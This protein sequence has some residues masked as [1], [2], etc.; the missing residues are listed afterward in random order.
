MDHFFVYLLLFTEIMLWG[1]AWIRFKGDFISPSIVTLSFF[2]VSTACF[3]YNLNNW[4]VDFGF[5]AYTF[6]T[7]AFVLMISVE[8]FI[9]NHK[10]VINKNHFKNYKIPVG[11][12]FFRLYILKPWDF[13]L[14]IFFFALSVFYIYRVYSSGVALG[15]ASFFSSIGYNKEFGEYD[16]IARLCFNLVRFTSY[17]YIVIFC[18]NFFTCKGKLQDNWKEFFLI[19]T[20]VILA[21]FSGQRSVMII[22]I[23]SFVVAIGISIFN[24]THNTKNVDLKKLFKK[25]LRFGIVL[26]LLFYYSANIVKGTDKEHAFVSYL[27]YYFGSTVCLMGR[28][29]YDPSLCHMPFVGFF[30][31]KTFQG[32]WRDMYSFGI[33]DALPAER[34]YINMG[35]PNMPIRAGNEYTFFCGPYIDFGYVGALLFVVLFYLLFSY[36]YYWKIRKN[37]NF[38]NKSII[39]A[40]YIFLFAMVAMAFYQDTIRVYSRVI[41]LAYIV[42]IVIF[43]KTFVKQ[44]AI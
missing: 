18:N 32:F 23:A 43:F 31:E 7:T 44:K 42:Y 37:S 5:Y 12:T 38:R 15:A 28:I 35:D 24:R 3:C 19:F 29:I 22:Y 13:F 26:I 20:T 4:I 1:F 14:F 9:S 30:G 8:S 41:N 40:I 25:V 6:F 27:T 36:L 2:I 21:F 11:Q 10:V 33:V 16:T 17:I 39:T 34:R